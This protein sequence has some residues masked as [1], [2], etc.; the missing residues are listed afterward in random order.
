MEECLLQQA[1]SSSWISD[2]P[3]V[4]EFETQFARQHGK[5]F[6]I[7]T[8]NG[9]SALYLALLTLGIKA[10][11]EVLVSGFGFMAAANMILSVGAKPIY[12]DIDPQT[13]CLDIQDVSK[14]VTRKAKAIVVIHPYGN[15]SDMEAILKFAKYK[16]LCVIEDAAQGLFSRYK[17]HLAGAM[18]DI[19]CFSFQATKTITMGE[20]GC[21]VTSHPGLYK[22][23][24]VI[25]NHGMST[26]QRYWHELIG[27][28]F[29]LTNMQAALGVAQL[30]KAKRIVA[31]KNKIHKLYRS[32]LSKEEGI[33]FQTFGREVR[34]VVWATAI[35]L[36]PKLFGS[37]DRVIKTLG[38]QGIEVR[39]GFYPPSAMPFYK[40][41]KLPVAESIAS[42]VIVLPSFSSM[43][44]QEICYVCRQLITLKKRQ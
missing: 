35:R 21:V 39:P 41:K 37:R 2:G 12:V 44:E 36:D 38:S 25:R 29:R 6:C 18:G 8:N 19:G 33:I 20:G 9:T 15:I 40:T 16:G 43:T 7:T 17:G 42:Q 28:N 13:W 4:K 14:K 24:Q 3:F 5:K 23:M 31:L 11:D 32:Y 22:R 34:P 30:K 27:H 10:K 26:A 1:V